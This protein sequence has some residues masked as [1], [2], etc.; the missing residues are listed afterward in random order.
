M[1]SRSAPRPARPKGG[2]HRA[3][4]GGNQHYPNDPVAEQ[5]GTLF[6]QRHERHA[7][8]GMADQ[9]DWAFGYHLLKHCVQVP[10]GLVD[11]GVLARSASGP[12][13]TTLIPRD[14]S[15][16]PLQ[17]GA[18]QLPTGVVEQKAVAQHHGHGC[19]G[20][21]IDFH[22]QPDTVV[23]DDHPTIGRSRIKLVNGMQMTP[24]YHRTLRRTAPTCPHHADRTPN[25][26][27]GAGPTLLLGW[28]SLTKRV[29]ESCMQGNL[30]AA[31]AVVA[32]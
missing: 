22:M 32:V 23:S 31:R 12:P 1:V 4:A 25:V 10:A 9:H 28:S 8:H 6:S 30:S 7:A 21:A 2:G 5:L 17:H 19:T 27:L 20:I 14:D 18:L 24:R 26:Q 15:C 11:R 3:R 16:L 13:M 29:A